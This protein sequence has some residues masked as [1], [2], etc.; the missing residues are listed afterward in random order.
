M[1][2]YPSSINPPSATVVNSVT[3][4]KLL[5]GKGNEIARHDLVDTLYCSNYAE[6]PTTPWIT[7]IKNK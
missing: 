5:L 7:Y 4:Y 1:K 6:S 3:I 2:E